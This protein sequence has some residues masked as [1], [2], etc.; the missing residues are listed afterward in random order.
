MLQ[1]SQIEEILG[2]RPGGNLFPSSYDEDDIIEAEVAPSVTCEM[3][4]V[5]NGTAVSATT[6]KAKSQLSPCEQ[7]ALEEAVARIQR[8]REQREAQQPQNPSSEV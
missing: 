2:K 6:D 5:E 4:V 1:Q 8:A 7:K 3:A